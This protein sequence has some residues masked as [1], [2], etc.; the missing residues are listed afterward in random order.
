MA[1]IDY[2]LWYTLKNNIK[3]IL[4]A[5]AAEET[6]VSAGRNFE[7]SSN[8]FTPWLESQQNKALVNIMVQTVGLNADR[9]G[10]RRNGMDNITVI[11]DMYALGRPVASGGSYLPSDDVAADR[12][13]LLVAQVRE[14]L[15]RLNLQDFG[16]TPDPTYGHMIDRNINF[17]LTYYDHENL[18][19]TGQYAPA[20]WSFDVMMPFIP[21]DKREYPDL[22][23][24]NITV[25]KDDLDNFA[26]R[27]TYDV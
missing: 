22:S 4:T 5:V 11:L 27:F 16:F 6:L 20:R 8:R 1:G 14:G 3:T 12:L 7:V 26:A 21:V 18:E 15:T 9:S 2:P 25:K 19:S 17:S 24:L 23:E 13:D 10:S